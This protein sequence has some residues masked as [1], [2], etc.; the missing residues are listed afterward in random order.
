M[1]IQY[2]RWIHLEL[3]LNQY[4][5]EFKNYE[6]LPSRTEGEGRN[7]CRHNRQAQMLAIC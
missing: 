4:P 6:F 3:A 2:K 7:G 5:I 1:L